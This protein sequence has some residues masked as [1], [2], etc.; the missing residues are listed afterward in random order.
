MATA[1]YREQRAVLAPPSLV[2]RSAAEAESVGY[3]EAIGLALGI[4]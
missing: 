3:L 2:R 4:D 1:L